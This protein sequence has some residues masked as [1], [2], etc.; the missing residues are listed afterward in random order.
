MAVS[1]VALHAAVSA[2]VLVV[3]V[4]VVAPGKVARL[5]S[6]WYGQRATEAPHQGDLCT[7]AGRRSPQ[8]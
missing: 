7:A 2:A 4:V 1:A 5:A 6:C 3:V 8:G